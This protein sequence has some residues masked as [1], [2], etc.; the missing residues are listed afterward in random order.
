MT[1]CWQ[2]PYIAKKDF[3]ISD[4]YTVPSG[5]I[6]MPALYPSL[7]DPEVYPEPSSF[8]PERWLDENSPANTK[9]QNFMVFGAGPHKC[10]GVE[11]TY[12]HLACTVGN[13]AVMMN[14]DHLRTD[15]SEGVE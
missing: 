6:V 1:Q 12:M 10:I 2:V 13:A 14:W 15:K 8:K 9:P 7:H 11:Y 4:D 5:S 3:P